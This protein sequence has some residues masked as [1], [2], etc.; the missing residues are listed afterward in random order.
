MRTGY[1]WNDFVPGESR[2]RLCEWSGV[3]GGWWAGGDRSEQLLKLR[4]FS[5]S[6]L[7]I[8]FLSGDPATSAILYP[9]LSWFN[10][11]VGKYCNSSDGH[12]HF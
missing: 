12:A 8:T 1:G 7:M 6:F 3:A 4:G 2:R 11:S 9:R 10:V 5:N